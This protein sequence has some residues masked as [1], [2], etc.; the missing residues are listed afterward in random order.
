MTTGTGEA[1]SPRP[2]GS[3]VASP[4]ATAAAGS[5]AAMSP[6]GSSIGAGTSAVT[7]APLLQGEAGLVPDVG[8]QALLF[9][10]AGGPVGCN[11]LLLAL[12]RQAL[13]S[14]AFAPC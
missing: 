1:G 11:G 13:V 7:G 14:H 5:A 2:V 10:E 12:C 8:L 3:N 6:R 4:A 9:G